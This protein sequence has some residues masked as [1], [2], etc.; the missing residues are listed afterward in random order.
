M[1][2]RLA[3]AAV[4]ALLLCRCSG[5]PASPGPVKPADGPPV[6][7]AAAPAILVGAGDIGKCG[8]EG[9][10]QTARLLDG[11]GGAVFAA[12]DNAY[13]NGTAENYRDC[14]DP[15]WGRH[16]ARTRPAP[17]NHE[18]ETAGASA[19]FSYFGGNAGA[20]GAGYYSYDLGAWHVVSLNSE[21]D[22]Q[23]GGQQHQWL[24]ADLAANRS[25]CVAAYWHKPR[26]SSGPHGNNVHMQDL[27]NTLNEFGVEI[28]VSAHDHLYERFAPQNAAGSLDP[29]RGVRQFVVGTGGAQ[30]YNATSL[31]PNSET[32]GSDWGVLKLTLLTGSYT[33]DFVPVAGASYRDSGSGTCH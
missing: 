9:P 11:I 7:N 10:Q 23:A 30:M 26:F 6:T 25:G 14:Y 15:A 3:T 28:L 31:R 19:Y 32:Q 17:G 16:K 33:W 1:P 18:Y 8:S 22:T 20:A 5:N 13:P 4:A 21:V 27:W 24:R 29:A 12:G 2:K